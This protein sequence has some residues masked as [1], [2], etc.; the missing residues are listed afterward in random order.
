MNLV[1]A[2]LVTI[3]WPVKTSVTNPCSEIVL[4]EP[5][6]MEPVQITKLRLLGITVFDITESL[7]MDGE[8]VH[9]ESCYCP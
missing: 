1:K 8:L 9:K 6:L 2:H 7:G 3:D 4:S 5:V